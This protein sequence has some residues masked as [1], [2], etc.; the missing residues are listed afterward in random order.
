[1][2]RVMMIHDMVNPDDQEGRT[3]REINAEK[4]HAIPMGTLVEIQPMDDDDSST[5]VRLFVVHH[6]RDCDQTPLYYLSADR[7]DTEKRREGFRNESW[8]GG[9]REE[10][11]RPVQPTES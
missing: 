2:P 4:V 11:I 7:Y 3:Y 1:M 10:L 8:F 6:G 9:I 5:G